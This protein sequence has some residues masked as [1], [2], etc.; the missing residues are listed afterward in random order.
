MWIFKGI[1]FRFFLV[2]IFDP[3]G[4]I[5]TFLPNVMISLNYAVLL[6]EN[7]ALNSDRCQ[8]LKYKNKVDLFLVLNLR[9]KKKLRK[10]I[11]KL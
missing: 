3:E 4:G 7:H 2:L 1:F 9:F 10:P 8:K 6:P 11:K 5:D